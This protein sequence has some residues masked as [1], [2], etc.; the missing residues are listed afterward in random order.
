MVIIGFMEQFSVADAK[1]HLSRILERVEEGEEIILTRRGRAV[2][3]I[4]ALERTAN[5]LGAGR[6]DPNINHEALASDD[7]WQPI[8]EKDVREWYE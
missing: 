3:R 8:S 4:V 6:H 7:W 1:T 5:I 2:A